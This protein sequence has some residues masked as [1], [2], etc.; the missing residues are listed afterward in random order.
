MTEEQKELSRIYNLK[1]DAWLNF[2]MPAR[3]LPAFKKMILEGR[4][5]KEPESLLV[6]LFSRKKRRLKNEK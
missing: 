6:K 1:M 3:W 2:Y 5:E 4:V